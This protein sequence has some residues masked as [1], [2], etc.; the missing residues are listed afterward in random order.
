MLAALAGQGWPQPPCGEGLSGAEERCW[1]CRGLCKTG[2]LRAH[3]EVKAAGVSP[4]VV[5]SSC[6]PQR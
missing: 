4:G 5:L 3:R 1:P 6:V 2:A